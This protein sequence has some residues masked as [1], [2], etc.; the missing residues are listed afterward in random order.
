MIVFNTE[1]ICYNL[2]L[3]LVIILDVNQ[4]VQSIM[5]LLLFSA[6]YWTKIGGLFK[7]KPSFRE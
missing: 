4:N 6:L 1:R 5:F 2:F 7:E 3:F